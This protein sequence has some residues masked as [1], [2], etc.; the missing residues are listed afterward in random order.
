VANQRERSEQWI[1][2]FGRSIRTGAV[3][4][5]CAALSYAV[6][7]TDERESESVSQASQ[8]LA[9]VPTTLATLPP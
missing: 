5:F 7:Q 1:Y 2:C 6:A 9:G 4:I 8:A 3:V